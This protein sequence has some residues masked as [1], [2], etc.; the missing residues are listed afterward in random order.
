MSQFWK[1]VK[2][3]E[4]SLMLGLLIVILATFSVT[5]L[6]S[7]CSRGGQQGD[8]RDMGGTFVT[9]T[10]RKVTVSDQEFRGVYTRYSSI[11]LFPA[12]GPSLKWGPDIGLVDTKERQNIEM[13]VWTH[14]ATV[15]SAEDAG[16]RVGDEEL[17]EGI[18]T[19]VTRAQ[20]VMTRRRPEQ[21][22]LAFTPA[23][24]DRVLQVTGY[25]QPKADFE[26]TVREILLKDK[27]L[28]PLLD[29]M[30][31]SE[32]RA[33]AYEQWKAGRER[34]D[35]RF[36]AVPAA[37]FADRVAKE[38]TT[39]SAIAKQTDLLRQ[40]VSTAQEGK[41]VLQRATEHKDKHGAFAKDEAE[42]VAKEPGKV[43]FPG[44][45]LPNDAWGKPFAYA[46][47]GD[48][49]TVTSAGPDGQAGTADDVSADLADVLQGLGTLRTVGDAAFTWRGV[50]KAWPRPSP[51]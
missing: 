34:V 18:R 5:G 25:R 13:A 31:F 8:A 22:A 42:L 1:N 47:A 16:Y 17:A 49:P 32:D 27:Y 19:I 51:T 24:Y 43:A 7:Q 38:E 9:A 28:T 29:S 2:K 46:L 44:G 26:R 50:A 36:V 15:A 11:Y 4:R 40:L 12:W 10:G 23:L 48:V 20:A 39:R 6:A 21:S 33:A 30:R 45:K 14:M 41:R 3:Y 35:L 37:Q